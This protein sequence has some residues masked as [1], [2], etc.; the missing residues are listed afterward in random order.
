MKVI[1]FYTQLLS[2]LK[3]LQSIWNH[4]QGINKRFEF[5]EF[6]VIVNHIDSL[7]S[8]MRLKVRYQIH[9][10]CNFVITDIEESR[11]TEVMFNPLG[12][13]KDTNCNDAW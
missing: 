10:L 4:W 1:H 2:S 8:V 11:A 13:H 12:D 6:V 3:A 7:S 5:N 9:S